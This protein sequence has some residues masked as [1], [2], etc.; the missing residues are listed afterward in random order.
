MPP[1]K[2]SE[3]V[4]APL[5]VYAAARSVHAQVYA[6]SAFCIAR[7]VFSAECIPAFDWQSVGLFYSFYH[8]KQPGRITRLLA[9]EDE[10]LRVRAPS[11]AGLRPHL[12]LHTCARARPGQVYPKVNLEMGPTFVHKNMRYD[13]MNEAEKFDQYHDG[14]GRGCRRRCACRTTLRTLRTHCSCCTAHAARPPHTPTAHPPYAHR[15]PTARPPHCRR[16]A[17]SPR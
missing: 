2:I 9:C 3:P 16:S 13:K 11:K 14:K 6:L 5:H 17:S 10:Q 7:S 4:A 12:R 15:T 1:L 8:S